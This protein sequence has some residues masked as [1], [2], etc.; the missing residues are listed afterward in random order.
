[1]D[2]NLWK[3]T[4]LFII[5]LQKQIKII[6]SIEFSYG[7]NNKFWLI[8]CCHFCLWFI[9]IKSP[10]H[11][12]DRYPESDTIEVIKTFA[13]IFRGSITLDTSKCFSPTLLK[14]IRFVLF[15]YFNFEEN[16]WEKQNEK[17]LTKALQKRNCY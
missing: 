3:I 11:F 12:K 10:H 9:A 13:L 8:F 4:F 5:F 17:A 2:Q 1:M 14:V 16:V 7:S 6:S 15:Y